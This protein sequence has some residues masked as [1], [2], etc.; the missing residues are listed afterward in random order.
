MK[1]KESRPKKQV[2]KN[3]DIYSTTPFST[4]KQIKKFPHTFS[5]NYFYK[6]FAS[7]QNYY[8]TKDINSFL[9]NQPTPNVILFQET[10]LLNEPQE[11][12]RRFY[13]HREI[14]NRLEILT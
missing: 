11:T 7:S 1:S 6:K 4:P 3:Q 14:P 13:Q 12:L 10:L 8:F 5:N 2:P 9:G